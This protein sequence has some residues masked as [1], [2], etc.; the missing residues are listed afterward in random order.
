MKN[1]T[2]SHDGGTQCDSDQN[3]TADTAKPAEPRHSL[4]IAMSQ[5]L[6]AAN[7][8]VPDTHIDALYQDSDISDLLEDGVVYLG[9]ESQA[10]VESCNYILSDCLQQSFI[11]T[12]ALRRSGCYPAHRTLTPQVAQRKTKEA[13]RVNAHLDRGHTGR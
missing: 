12:A 6:R 10:Q 5:A 1:A 4:A 7:V 9:K 11:T 13:D 8:I 3:H 2:N